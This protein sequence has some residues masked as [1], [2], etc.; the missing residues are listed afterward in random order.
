ARAEPGAGGGLWD[1]FLARVQQ[2]EK[3]VYLHL[4]SGR[5]VST[6]EGALRIGIGNESYRRELSRKEIL[7]RLSAIA[8]EAVGNPVRVEVGPLPAE[9]AADTPLAQ[10]RRRTEET[11]ADPMVQAAVEIFGAEVRGVRE[12]RGS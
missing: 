1:R 12:R 11:L 9:L 8:R 7:D 2:A 6:D 4:A 5:L 10:A 3:G